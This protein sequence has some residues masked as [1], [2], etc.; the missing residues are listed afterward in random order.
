MGK[1]TRKVLLLVF[2]RIKF[3]QDFHQSNNARLHKREQAFFGTIL[4]KG[5]AAFVPGIQ[6]DKNDL[7]NMF[8]LYE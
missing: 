2:S 6:I 5:S 7:T 4:C 1:K 8:W 3:T